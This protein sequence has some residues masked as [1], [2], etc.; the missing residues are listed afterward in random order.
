MRQNHVLEGRIM[1]KRTLKMLFA[2]LAVLVVGVAL[3]ACGGDDEGAAGET[4]EAEASSEPIKIGAPVDLSGVFAVYGEQQ[5]Q[6]A[7][8]AVKEINEAG[9]INGRQVEIVFA[10]AQSDVQ[11]AVEQVKSL[12]DEEDVDALIGIVSSAAR[13][14]VIPTVA[15]AEMVYIYPTTY[16]GG[17]AEK[18]SGKG[19]KYVFTTGPVSE[20]YISPF[21]PWLVEKYGG[22]IY[23][24][25][26]DYIYGTGSAA[27]AKAAIADAGG[28]VVGEE[29]VPLG[30]TDFSAIL[31]RVERAN[32]DVVYAVIAGE[33]LVFLM[34][35]YREFGLK[36]KG[37]TFATTELDESYFEGLG[38]Q[39]VE[40]TP[41]SL[42]YFVVMDN[43]ENQRWL[44]AMRAEYGDDLVPGLAAESMY[45]SVKLFAEAAKQAGSL[46]TDALI[47]ALEGVSIDTPQGPVSIREEDHQA[48]MGDAI[49]IVEPKEGRPTYEWVKIQEQFD[50]IEPSLQGQA[51]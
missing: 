46:E 4:G 39:V 10:D 17:V 20:Q 22:D 35:Q 42:P 47:A 24:L 2:G 6:G 18:F 19:A 49:A 50:S 8:L 23:I 14:A 30:T 48:I 45:Y 29:L 12:I 16:E 34:Q 25:A 32:P 11:P 41:I 31:N 28:T 44:E 5:Q 21:M 33:D 3:A 38:P 1:K 36:N 9:G 26:M 27:A 15:R 37:I 43:E 40:G 7:E 13:D 51:E